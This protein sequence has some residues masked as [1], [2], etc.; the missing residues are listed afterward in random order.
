MSKLI[1]L[2]NPIEIEFT[3]DKKV[4][5]SPNSN[6]MI[7]RIFSDTME[8][9]PYLNP[10][11]NNVS[12]KVNTVGDIKYNVKYKAK[13][14]EL[15]YDKKWGYSIK[16]QEI[17]PSDFSADSINDDDTMLNFIELFIGESVADKLKM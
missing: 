17:I 4:Y 2:D 14:M 6:F 1:K 15:E 10:V 3:L 11:Y 5:K 16:G 7:L 12:M 8:I 9:K 13:I